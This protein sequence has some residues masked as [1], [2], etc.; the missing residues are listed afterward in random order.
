VKTGV[1]LLSFL[2]VTRAQTEAQQ[3]A[4]APSIATAGMVSSAHPLATQAGLDLLAR[5]ANAFDAAIAVAATLNVVEPMMSGVGGYGTILIYDAK[6]REVRYLN[7]SGRI[8]RGVNSD[9]FRPPTPGYLEN[10]RGAK[11]VST[12]GNLHAWEALAREYGGRPWR[13]L[14]DR[15]IRAAEDGYPLS[16]HQARMIADAFPTFPLHAKAIYGRGGAPLAAGERLVQRDLA[17]SLR[18]ISTEGARALYGGSLGRAVDSAMRAAGGFLSLDDLEHDRAE[19]Y[20]PISLDYRGSQVYTASPPANAFDALARLGM[21]SRYDV[22]ALG[23]NSAGYLHRYAEVTKLGFWLRLRYAGDP[24]LQPPPV[25]RLLSAGYLDSLVARIDTARASSFVPPGVSASELPATH[26]TH[27]VVADRRGNVVSATQTIGNLFGS[28]IMPEGT[29][30]WLNNSLEY[31]TFE[32]K[33]NPMDAFAGRHKLSGDVPTIV[34]RDGRPWAAIGTPGG[35]SIGQTV[36]QMLIDLI[37]FGM[38]VQAAIAAPRISFAE[39][40]LLLVEAGV[41]EAVRDRLEQL[42][43]RLRV[44]PAGTG[45]GNAHGLTI[46]YDAAGRPLRFTGGADPRG[47]GLAQGPSK[48]R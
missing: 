37:D 32:P 8:P 47:E 36:P 34:I 11:A 43:H 41:P 16:E 38:D 20:Q 10:R 9:E 22:G 18:L 17:R 27:F 19:W 48:A 35:H 42:G 44:L 29:G 23:H 5:G 15:A 4:L 33:G 45:I 30:I 40:D 26:T 3:P 24:E 28:R 6:R 39:P 7:P 2:A 12:P 46:E 13:T 1:A 25:E 31:S 14:F 21:M